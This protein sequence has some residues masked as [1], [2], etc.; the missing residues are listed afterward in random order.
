[1]GNRQL[2]LSF[3]PRHF[4]IPYSIFHFYGATFKKRKVTNSQGGGRRAALVS[5]SGKSDPAPW[6]ERFG[7]PE[8]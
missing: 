4:H 2:K 3:I 8:L 7:V 6:V 1:M 5:G